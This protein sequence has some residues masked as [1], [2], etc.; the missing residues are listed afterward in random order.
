[1]LKRFLISV[2]IASMAI[3]VLA[4]PQCSGCPSN[5]GKAKATTGKSD[6]KAT[7]KTEGCAMHASKG[8]KKTEA[9]DDCCGKDPFIMEANRMAAAAEGK[10]STGCKCE[11]KANAAKAKA[12]AKK[13]AKK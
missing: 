9:K 7:A 6:K 13:K 11:D 8:A 12:K 3:S 10:K 4:A 1:M 5:T 2:V